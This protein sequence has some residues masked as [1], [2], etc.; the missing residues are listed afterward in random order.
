MRL[1]AVDFATNV[2]VA[3]GA[4]GEIPRLISKSLARYEG[5][6]LGDIARQLMDWFPELVAVH[7]PDV[8]IIEAPL[9]PAASRGP[10]AARIAFGGDFVVKGCASRIGA[11]CFEVHNGTWKADVLGSG[12]LP[13][14]RAKARSMEIARAFDLAPENDNE[15]DAFCIW[16][17]GMRAHLQFRT[18]RMDEVIAKA[19]RK[20]L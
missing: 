4:K 2:G 9:P 1:M 8:I 3:V 15:S 10:E 12:N 5:A 18:Q 11:R 20:L 7:A 13:S 19:Q 17:Y 16:L 14:Y 6:T